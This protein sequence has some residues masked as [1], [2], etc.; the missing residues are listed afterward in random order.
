M[1]DLSPTPPA[2]ASGVAISASAPGAL[3]APD[4]GHPRKWWILAAVSFGMFMALLDV[5]IV[6]IAVPAILEDLDTT[7]S[8]VSWVIN[9]YSLA[10]AVLFLSMG[11]VS[12]KYGQKVVFVGGLVVFTL[13]SL[14]CGLAPDIEWLVVFR[15]GQGVG[16]AAMAPISLAILLAAF[17]RRQHGMAVGVW[18]AMG[19]I[20]GAVGPTL[21]GILIEYL[22]WHWIFFVNVPVGFVALVMAVALVPERRPNR[23]ARGIDVPGILISAVGLFCLVLA[24]IQGNDWGWGTTRIVT[25][26]AV[27]FA[28]FPL[29]LWWELRTP[30]PMFD[31]RLLRIRSFTAAN[32]SMMFVGAALGGTMF[33]LVI[34]LVNVLGYSELRAAI[35]I[36]P[37]PLTGLIVAPNV[38]RLVDRVG[39]RVPALIGALFFFA[40]LVLLAQLGGASTLWDVTWRV[41]LLGAGV[42][43]SMP[44]LSAAAMGSL[45]PQVAGVGSGALNTLRQIGFS[46]GLAVVVAL[47]SGTIA[48]NVVEASREAAKVVQDDPTLPAPAK[49]AITAG[50]AATAAA[51]EVGEGDPRLTSQDPLVG[52][53]AAP[54]G[55][56]EAEQQAA[57]KSEIAAIF[58]DN[59][60]A[61]FTWPFY[62]MALAALLAAVPALFV[63][64]RLGEHEGHH[65]MNRAERAEAAGLATEAA[66]AAAGDR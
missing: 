34:F 48:D 7:V 15:I 1:S 5:T 49:Q 19:T 28:S 17:P 31:F 66:A 33:L 29:F 24:L 54:P 60:A 3:P 45:P 25:L 26:F 20:A 38:G 58:R 10:L 21:G 62:A 27:A 40:G 63:G 41:V 6:N 22:S 55:S 16:G 39:P 61:S 18:G 44:T 51:A 64:R 35:A 4:S 46:V 65:E 30:S 36:T 8:R 9:A 14:A 52:V 57:L 50:L 32:T 59:V 12:D 56:P 2:A 42:G 43:F 13:A 11:R 23:H 47:F 53:P 37:M